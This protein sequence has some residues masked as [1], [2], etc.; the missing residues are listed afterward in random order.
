LLPSSLG[1]EYDFEFLPE[2][3]AEVVDLPEEIRREIARLVLACSPIRT[4]AI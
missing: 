2:V 3:Q 1:A 4:G